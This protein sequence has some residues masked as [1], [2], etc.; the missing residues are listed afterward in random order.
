MD[1]EFDY[2]DFA[3]NATVNIDTIKGQD[4]K[5]SLVLLDNKF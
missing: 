2:T 3:V 5:D 4:G 1:L